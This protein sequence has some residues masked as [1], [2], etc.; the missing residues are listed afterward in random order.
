ML[1]SI[2]VID[3]TPD[4]I[5]DLKDTDFE[6]RLSIPAPPM[7]FSVSITRELAIIQEYGRRGLPIAANLALLYLGYKSN[8]LDWLLNADKE[9]IDRCY[10]ELNYGTTIYP[11]VL[12]H[13]KQRTFGSSKRL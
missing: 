5:V 1:I 8:N 3:W 2:S 10:P 7:P 4:R 11:C 13:I 6:C 12:R 9:G